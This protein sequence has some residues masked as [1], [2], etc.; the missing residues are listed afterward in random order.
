MGIDGQIAVDSSEANDLSCDTR[1]HCFA[2]LAWPVAVSPTPA[3]SDEPRPLPCQTEV[4]QD[5]A[6]EERHAELRWE[7]QIVFF[8][9]GSGI[10]M[11]GD[12]Q[13]MLHLNQVKPR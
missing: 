3:W 5:I 11:N 8:P 10:I 1:E 7:D 9:L 6:W 2:W 13:H 4:A 12:R